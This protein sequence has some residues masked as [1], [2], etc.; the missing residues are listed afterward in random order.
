MFTVGDTI[1]HPAYGA[2][3]I[4]EINVKEVLGEYREYYIIE[5][6]FKN[7]TIMI[8]TCKVK[9]SGIRQVIG[10]PEAEELLEFLSR[11]ADICS[12]N[13][14]KR[15]RENND[16]IRTGD[17]YEV[18]YVVRELIWRECCKGLSSREK[19]MLTGAKK[20]LLS[21]ISC[22]VGRP[23]DDIDVEIKEAVEKIS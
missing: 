2:G 13:W 12:D 4:R 16:K 7:E 21:E 10:R 11:P 3:R 19:K 14:N 18:A 22:A 20:I 17:L 23:Y 1:V 5:M 15:Y 6:F 8:P 9:E